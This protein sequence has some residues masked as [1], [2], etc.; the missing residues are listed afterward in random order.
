M[1]GRWMVRGFVAALL[2][3]M[4]PGG[5]EV[6]A[7]GAVPVAGSLT[8]SPSGMVVPGEQVRLAGVLPPAK[9]RPV[10]LQTRVGTAA[11]HT[12]ARAT[13][14]R[15]GRFAF[16]AS[17]TG[18]AGSRRDYRVL[19]PAAR[20]GG[21]RLP[22]RRTPT[23]SYR[24]VMPT[25]AL[26]A[27]ELVVEGG[28]VAATAAF[29]PPRPGRPVSLE[30]WNGSAWVHL[31]AGVEDAAGETALDAV[32]SPEGV[33]RLRAT[34]AAWHGAEPVETTEASVHVLA[35]LEVGVFH[36]CFVR[37]D[38]TGWCW[39]W[40]T[41]GQ[42]GDGHYVDQPQPVQVPGSDWATLAAGAWHTCGLK[43]DGTAW[44]WGD[45]FY[46]ELGDGTGDSSLTPVQ[47]PGDWVA[48]DVDHYH[49]CGIRGDGS[50]WC[51][52]DNRTGQ[53]GDGSVEQRNA[54]VQVGSATDWVE[55]DTANA[56]TCGRRADG[57]LW[58]WGNNGSGQ[59]GDD[60]TS[61]RDAPVR[62]GTATDWVQVS[63]AGGGFTCGLRG[64]GELWCW[65]ADNNGTLG[66]GSFGDDSHVPVRVGSATDWRRVDGGNY[67][68]CGV[69]AGGT[70]WCWGLNT[71]G[72]L[73]TGFPGNSSAP[74]QVLH[75]D[76]TPRLSSG[77]G[78][79]CA[80]DVDNGVW[81]WGENRYGQVGDGTL[82][83]DQSRS[84]PVPVLWP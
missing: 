36:S 39:G 62:V 1:V 33:L 55:V 2:G 17:V 12:V 81:C 83:V 61:E 44:C 82:G 38:A 77:S 66:N 48:L 19:A 50:L 23:V 20:V 67:Q 41:F 56:H 45:N 24:L 37:P 8:G 31:A 74:V 15:T 72:Q 16:T 3:T 79:V 27:Q 5:L 10:R 68:A 11:W 73:G 18:S 32:A 71:D 49:G 78:H 40:D 9:A 51:W 7:A 54:P 29:G 57:S 34:A 59:V 35:R 52:G 69:R 47:V 75:G 76:W 4:L 65:G 80:L 60:S 64:A 84:T 30:G 21:T 53:L 43:T 13:S 42:L 58:C 70:A 22:A 26:T 28:H 14:K 6:A 25:V 46:G 63:A